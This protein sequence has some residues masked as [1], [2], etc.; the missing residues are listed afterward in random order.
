MCIRDR[1]IA[2]KGRDFPQWREEM[3]ILDPSVQAVVFL[4]PG[5]KKAAPLYNDIKLH[6]LEHS[7]VPSQV[8]LLKTVEGGKGLRSICN[9]ILVQICAKVGGVPWTVNNLP[10]TDKPTMIVGIDV[11]HKANTKEKTKSILAFCS[12]VNNTF[13]RYWST[14][15]YQDQYQEIGNT[16]QTAVMDSLEEFFQTNKIGPQRVIV[17]RDGVSEA[18]IKG[19][20]ES[21]VDAFLR[22]FQT[23]LLYTSPSPRDR[24]KSRM[25]S[26]A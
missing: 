14:L 6:L 19:V 9:K 16:M 11:Y 5:P 8:V 21:E 4:L 10:F 15:R 12:T 18:Q 1:Q 24:Q 7:P 17:Y 3:K 26:S 23:C 2:V 25:P 13:S 20:R 22:A